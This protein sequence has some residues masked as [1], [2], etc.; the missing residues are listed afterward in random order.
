MGKFSRWKYAKY[1]GIVTCPRCG[2][3]GYAEAGWIMGAKVIKISHR[4]SKNGKL[5]YSGVHYA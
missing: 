5:R 2:N 1:L 4:A 3:R